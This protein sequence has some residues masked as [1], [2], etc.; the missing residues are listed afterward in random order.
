MDKSHRFA[1]HIVLLAVATAGCKGTSEPDPP[2]PPAEIRAVSNAPVSV[3]IASPGPVLT[4]QVVDANGKGVPNVLVVWSA[5]DGTV[6]PAEAVTD[7][8]GNV[9][10]TW[11]SGTRAGPRTITATATTTTGPRPASFGATVVEPRALAFDGTDDFVQVPASTSL[12]GAT[13]DFTWEIWLKPSRTGVRGDVMTKKDVF[14]DSEH[15]VAFVHEA[16]GR[17][18][19]FLRDRP[20][21]G[22]TVIITSRSSIGTEWTHVAMAR[23]AD[24][25]RL[26]VNGVLQRTGFAP[27]SVVSNGPLRIG[28]NRLND[29]GPDAAPVLPFAGL[30]HEV[31]VWS[32]ARTD[33]QIAAA[34][35]GCVSRQSAGLVA[36]YRFNEATGTTV[37]DVSGA[38]NN[39]TLR[40]GPVWVAGAGRCA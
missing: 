11:S 5:D 36:D 24:S 23:S 25:V 14:A 27:F 40:N 19:A 38:G 22:S 10:T 8:Q 39:G 32:V 37:R 7:E 2:G 6:S 15:D 34:A 35:R 30:V 12:Y 31:R 33:A 20:F 9:R 26:Y 28:A 29:A 21:T 18:S 13:R 3:P 1:A 17:V 16:T 4:A